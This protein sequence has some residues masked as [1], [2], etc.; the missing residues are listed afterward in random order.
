MASAA[1]RPT[2]EKLHEN[3]IPLLYAIL[4]VVT[5][6][7]AVQ[8]AQP[9][10]LARIPI[11]NLLKNELHASR[12]ATSAFFFWIGFP[13]YF[14]PFVGIFTDAFP[15]FGTRRRSYILINSSLAT[16][17]WAALSFTPHQYGKLLTVVLIV[18]FFMVI[19]STV[20]GGYMVESAQRTAGSGRFSAIFNIVS[21]ASVMISGPLGGYLASIAFGATTAA[22]GAV[23]FLL[24]PVAYFFL[25]EKRMALDPREM[26]GNAKTQLVN[27]AAARTMWAAAGL[28]ALF[29]IAPGFSTALFYRQQDV[30]HLNTQTQGILQFLGGV[31]SVAAA[32]W[33]GLT[34]KRVNLRNLLLLCLTVSTVT[35]LGYLV[36]SSLSRARVIDGINGVGYTMAECALMALAIRAT[37]KG[38][39]GLGF[40]LMMSVRNFALFGSDIFGSWL[41]D[42]YRVPFGALVISNSA[43]TAIAI[44]LVLLLPLSLVAKKDAEPAKESAAPA[45]ASSELADE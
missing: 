28:M 37:P 16:I 43:I 41:L 45:F 22:C 1:N 14:K 3:S 19:T 39:E 29:Y 26:L 31:G 20:I 35:N 2:N 17:S 12:T 23:M 25:R 24:V 42:K 32:I 9:Q 33:Y 18:N 30:L 44:P 10:V 21:W 4:V 5:G 36:Y 38:S 13:W 27:I 34:C 15:L 7:L 8:L 6:I 11:Q 40:S